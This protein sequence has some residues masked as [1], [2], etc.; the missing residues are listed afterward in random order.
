MKPEA[1]KQN[2][3][4]WQERMNDWQQSGLSASVWCKKHDIKQ[5]LFFYWKRKLLAQPDDKLIPLA[6]V[7]PEPSPPSQVILYMDSIRIEAAP[8]QAAALIKALQAVS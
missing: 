8:E 3:L 7:Q 4:L 6:V 5:H 2:H 1:R